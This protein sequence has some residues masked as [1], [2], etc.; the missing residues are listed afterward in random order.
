MHLGKKVVE[1]GSETKESTLVSDSLTNSIG[2]WQ[3]AKISN[4]MEY[5]CNTDTYGSDNEPDDDEQRSDR[6]SN[7]GLFD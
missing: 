2:S 4:P 7:F 3:N 6:D 1:G 5:R